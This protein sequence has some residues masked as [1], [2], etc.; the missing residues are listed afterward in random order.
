MSPACPSPRT[1]KS[2]SVF[3]TPSRREA[4]RDS[5]GLG[6]AVRKCRQ[7]FPN[8]ATSP[9][10]RCR[11]RCAGWRSKEKQIH[12]QTYIT[13]VKSDKACG[14]QGGAILLFLE[15][16]IFRPQDLYGSEYRGR[17][18]PTEHQRKPTGNQGSPTDLLKFH[19]VSRGSVFCTFT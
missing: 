12:A 8:R 5:C 4:V 3:A 14:S 6:L 7:G 10:R 17:C 18:S 2:C 1:G 15:S 16:L 19:V 13:N 9:H 11:S